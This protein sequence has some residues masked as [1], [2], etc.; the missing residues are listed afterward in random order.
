MK[1]SKLLKMRNKSSQSNFHIT[2]AIRVKNNLIMPDTNK[3]GAILIF[4]ETLILNICIKPK[5]KENMLIAPH[6][7]IGINPI[8]NIALNSSLTG[9]SPNFKFKNFLNIFSSLKSILIPI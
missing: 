3:P 7:I 4:G 5:S 2:T 6:A 8:K 9:T 1:T